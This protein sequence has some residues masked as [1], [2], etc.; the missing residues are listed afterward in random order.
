VSRLGELFTFLIRVSSATRLGSRCK[1]A[2]APTQACIKNDRHANN[3]DP[4]F[5]ADN[6]KSPV[7]SRPATVYRILRSLYT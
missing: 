1:R 4:T 5:Y 3:H 6:V 2:S 7:I